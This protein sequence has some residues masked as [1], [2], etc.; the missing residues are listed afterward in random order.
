MDIIELRKDLIS[1]FDDML[2][3]TGN[4]KRKYY[5]EI[6]QNG[7]EKY[8]NIPEEIRQYCKL[9]SDG[10]IAE[11]ID[12]LAPVLPDYAYEKIQQEKKSVRERLLIDYNMN[13]AVYVIP[14]LN[15]NN[16]EYCIQLTKK[17]VKMWNQKNLSSMQL[18]H[19]TYENIAG[20]FKVGCCYITTAVCQ[21]R[22]LPDDCRELTALR[23]F[24]DD[25]MCA[26]SEGKK[27]VEQYY[28]TAPGIVLMINMQ[29]NAQEIYERIYHTYIL[30]CLSYIEE[31]K[32]AECQAHYAAMVQE[33]EKNYRQEE[34][35]NE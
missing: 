31:G 26:D 32:N 3:H 11:L 6:F 1:L 33:L 18:S 20:G 15:Y 10:E 17:I 24:R 8:K 2:A 23:R 12:K 21:S 27:M 14:I 25:Y 16:N 5:E 29:K 30:P 13:M 19:S 9:A 28:E 34:R 7:Y 22:K 35:S 4:F